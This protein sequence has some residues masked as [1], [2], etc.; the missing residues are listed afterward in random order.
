MALEMAPGPHCSLTTEEVRHQGLRYAVLAG[1]VRAAELGANSLRVA[2]SED[3]DRALLEEALA[4]ERRCCPFLEI[5]YEPSERGSRI[6]I[7]ISDP[8]H[9]PILAAISGHLQ[10]RD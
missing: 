10:V 9:G 6:E 8:A 7:S 3:V 4:I 2:F 5:G 1:D